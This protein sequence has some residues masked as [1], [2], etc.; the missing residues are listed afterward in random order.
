MDNDLVS[1]IIPC[2]NAERWI[3]ETLASLLAQ[4]HPALEII[5][6]D[7]GSTDGST[8]LVEE[9][10]SEKVRL[11]RQPNSGASRARN[12]GLAVANG[13]FIQ[14]LDADD[15]LA[16]NKIEIQLRRLHDRPGAIAMA[17]WARFTGSIEQAAFRPDATWRDLAPM[18]WLVAAWVQGGGMLY[19]GMWLIPRKVVERAGPWDE[20][21]SLNDDGE[22]FTRVLLASSEVLFCEGSRSYYRSSIPGSLSGL[23]SARGWHSHFHSIEL[24]QRHVLAREESDRVRRCVSMLWQRFAHASYPFARELSE[25]AMRRAKGLHGVVLEPEG[26][27]LFRLVLRLAGWRVARRLQQWSYERRG[28]APRSQASSTLPSQGA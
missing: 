9:F 2:F 8:G 12:A 15:I 20:T 7:D 4:T 24:C 1:A 6:V 28:A 26:G 11:L 18:D 21:L 3:S 23:K 10:V 22:Y 14:F 5:V 17:E 19:P 13:E 25:E 16:P 27:P